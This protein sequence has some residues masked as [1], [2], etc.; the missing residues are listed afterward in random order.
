[1]FF[2]HSQN[3]GGSLWFEIRGFRFGVRRDEAPLSK[4]VTILRHT[5]RVHNGTETHHSSQASRY[6]SFIHYSFWFV[7]QNQLPSC[8]SLWIECKLWGIVEGAFHYFLPDVSFLSTLIWYNSSKKILRFDR[9]SDLP[10]QTFWCKGM[11]T[12][13][14]YSKINK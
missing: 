11:L 5:M 6:N 12:T 13:Q 8:T 1:M 9:G 14:I 7:Y 3:L 10:F 4:V 2:A